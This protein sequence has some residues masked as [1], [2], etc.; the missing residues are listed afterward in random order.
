VGG[1]CA[2]NPLPVI[3]PCHRV[4]RSNGSAGEYIGG[5]TAKQ[6]LLDLEHSYHHPHPGQP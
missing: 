5:A 4:I 2:T 6:K 3:M 1:A